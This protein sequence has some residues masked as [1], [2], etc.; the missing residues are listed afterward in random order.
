MSFV[1]FDLLLHS[2]FHIFWLPLEILSLY[3]YSLLTVLFSIPSLLFISPSIS[4]HWY[5][6]LH[7][8]TPPLCYLF[9]CLPWPHLSV[10]PHVRYLYV[11]PTPLHT[12]PFPMS[13]CLHILCSSSVAFY[14]YLIPSSLAVLLGWLALPHLPIF[15]PSLSILTPPSSWTRAPSFPVVTTRSSILLLLRSRS[16][17]NSLL[18]LFFRSFTSF[19]S[20][21]TYYSGSSSLYIP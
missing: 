8:S 19:Q 6:F 20:G 3:D 10:V 1:F 5:S 14:R 17:F 16:S 18:C 15:S 21:S 9:L 4:C 2:C 11:L 12:S 13:C 7:L